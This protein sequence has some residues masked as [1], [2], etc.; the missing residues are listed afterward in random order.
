MANWVSGLGCWLC[1]DGDDKM[2]RERF[3]CVYGSE[4]ST[5]QESLKDGPADTQCWT[6][7][8]S[9]QGSMLQ[10]ADT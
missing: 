7:T 9:T 8:R 2:R 6:L 10:Q 3:L 1:A 4:A 5:S